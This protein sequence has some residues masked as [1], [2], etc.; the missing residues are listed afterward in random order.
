MQSYVPLHAAADE[1]FSGG[2]ILDDGRQWLVEK[3]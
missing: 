3:H 1:V 2:I